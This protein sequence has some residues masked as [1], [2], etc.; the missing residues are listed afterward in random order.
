DDEARTL[1]TFG[2]RVNHGHI[3][4]P[5]PSN[6][7]LGLFNPDPL[8][9]IAY[10]VNGKVEVYQNLGNGLFEYVGERRVHGE[11]EKME[12]RK[13]RM[14]GPD[15]V[16]QFSWGGLHIAY[17]DGSSE[18]LTNEQLIHSRVNLAFAPQI[19]MPPPLDFR[20]VWRSQSQTRPATDLAI[21]E[22][23]SDGRTEVAYSFYP[24]FGDS[25]RLVVYECVGN[26]SFVVDWDTLVRG[27]F[28]SWTISDIDND[29]H[30]E[31]ALVKAG[32]V[33]MLECFGPGHYRYYQT[34]IA[35][36]FPPFKAIET[37]VD[38]NGRNELVLL[39]SNPSPP[40]GQDPTLI[41][42][43]EYVG[44]GPS[45]N[46]WVMVFNQQ[47]ARY[48]GYTFD[49]AVGQIDGLGR[50]EII[51][52]GGSFGVNEPVPINYLWYNGTTWTTRS[53]YTGL[54]SGTTAPMFVNLDADTTKELFI[55]GVGPI[56]HGSCYALD[57]VSDT[58]W[59]VMWADSSLRNTP[60][61]VNSGVLGGEFVVAGANTWDRSP[62]DTL[63]TQLHVYQ[64]SGVKLGIWQ[65]DTASVQNFHFLDIDNDGRTNL[66]TAVLSPY[67]NHLADYEYYGTNSVA[68]DSFVGPE[69]LQL[70]Q[71]YPN[72]FNPT[73]AFTI[74]LPIQSVV[75]VSVYDILGREVITLLNGEKPP[76][77]HT[78]IWH[79]TNEEG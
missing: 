4:H 27:M 26:D 76:G 50:D 72:P 62:L 19:P 47:I 79:G 9:D 69:G 22:I 46:G 63:Y 59:R 29:G 18:V 39:T 1:H 77:A 71:N 74:Y 78:Q 38:H 17:E 64:P 15:V 52:A 10:Y 36:P 33:V 70:S 35:Y 14:L 30:K 3:I 13:A 21:A 54:R 67:R 11:V 53:I 68:E 75:C 44:K 43:V 7:A 20:E 61:S 66:V 23:D 34:N 73:T 25:N 57:Y 6:V 37:D 31:L 24:E 48:G 49:M 42:V 12:W 41:Y 40:S 16:D 45:P 58:T 8:L 51:P 55:G 60:L 2:V 65:R 56:G 32:Q 5:F 28:G